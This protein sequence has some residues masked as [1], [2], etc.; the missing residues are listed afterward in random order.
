MVDKEQK[1][2]NFHNPLLW[3][4]IGIIVFGGLAIVFSI[5]KMYITAGIFVV[6]LIVCFF[7]ISGKDK[8]KEIENRKDLGDKNG[9]TK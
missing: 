7:G 1:T 4:V 6:A 9:N 2:T 5:S 8:E 3:W